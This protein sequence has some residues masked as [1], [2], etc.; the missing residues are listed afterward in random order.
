V[1]SGI[2]GKPDY[3]INNNLFGS[4]NCF[5]ACLKYDAKLIFISTSRVYPVDQIN[6]ISYTEDSTRFN[7]IKSSYLNGSSHNGISEEFSLYGPRSFYGTTK[8]SAELLI[9]E[10]SEFYNLKA[11]IVR[12]GVIA[13]PRQMGKI[14]QGVSTLWM[15]KHF[16][17]KP[18][19]YIG[20]EGKGKQV[21]DI[22]HI[23]DAV[24]LIDLQIHKINLFN[25]KIFNAGGGFL[26]SISLLEMTNLCE[27]ITGNKLKIDSIKQNRSADMRIYYSDNSKIYSHTGWQPKYSIDEI[28]RDIFKW[29]KENENQLKDL[30]S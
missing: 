27:K 18:L 4:I 8:L 5:N 9:Q 7:F 30:L 13:G 21:R 12:F 14:D 28:F 1:T 22:L 29:I 3:V 2:G 20:F 23:N 10:Y 17:K 19:N 15:A 24:D 6:N 26:N 25:K 16:W 11:S